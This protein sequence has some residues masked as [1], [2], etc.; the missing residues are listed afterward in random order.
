MRAS[1]VFSHIQNTFFGNKIFQ[2]KA[3]T[4]GDV[5]K[6]PHFYYNAA[7]GLIHEVQYQEPLTPAETGKVWKMT[8]CKYLCIIYYVFITL[9]K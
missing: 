9:V 3:Y 4:L 7:T 2:V 8:V 6:I 5:S 1:V